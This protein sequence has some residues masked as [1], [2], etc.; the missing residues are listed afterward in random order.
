MRQSS[1]IL[2]IL[3]AP[4]CAREREPVP[5]VLDDLTAA[6]FRDWEDEDTMREHAGDLARWLEVERDVGQ[7]WDGMRLSNLTPEDVGGVEYPED[8]DLS[9]HGG[10]ATAF[11]S[12]FPIE[13]HAS[14]LVEADQTFTDPRTFLQYDRVLLEGEREAFSVGEGLVRTDNVIRKAGAFGIE[15]PYT[16]RKDYRW[17]HDD[18]LSAILGRTWV[19]QPGCSE[20]GRNCVVQSWGVD[21]FVATEAG[22]HRLYAIWIEVNTE[23]DSFIGEDAKLGLVAN[24]NQDLLESTDEALASR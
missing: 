18:G 22:T 12:A 10:I 15:I 13:D 2:A 24:G 7:A 20:N 21:A 9:L 23:A 17:V 3:T 5:V 8:T 19:T 6:M 16:L 14:L 11:T 4:G 1:L